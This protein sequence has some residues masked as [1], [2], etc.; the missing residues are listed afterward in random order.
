MTNF[1]DNG[2]VMP[3][4][5]LSC[6]PED[7]SRGLNKTYNSTAL[8]FGVIKAIYPVSDPKN[9]GG[10]TTEYDVEVIE[11]DMNKGVA[12]VTYHNC[13][14]VDALSSVADFF[15]K[16]FR[17]QTQSDNYQ[18]P[19]TKGQNGATVLVLCLDATMGKGIVLGG[20]NHP[21]RPT[22]LV[23]SQP[24]LSGEYNGVAISV[25]PDGSASLTFKGPT[26]NDGIPT[27]SNGGTVFQIKPDGSF[28]F[29]HS[30]V[31]IAADKSGALMI[32]AKG[33]ANV[34]VGGNSTVTTSGDT[35]LTT[36]GKTIIKSKEI[37]MNVISPMSDLGATSS[38]SHQQV[39]DFI[40]GIPC[41]PSETVFI[42]T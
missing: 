34:T 13:M 19:I 15:E 26:D 39:I 11:Q 33:D 9:I 38:R 32:N 29:N 3:H 10:L 25:R 12:P 35:N 22:T 1:L 4:G 7:F 8:R 18:L 24:R 23:D 20:L 28:E 42:D 6:K 31:S 2:T 5:L 30:T 40:T 14:S 37:D 17:S 27:T 21:D 41:I 36:A 16:N